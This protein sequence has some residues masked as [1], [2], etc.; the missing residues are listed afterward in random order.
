MES[1]MKIEDRRRSVSQALD[2]IPM[3][4]SDPKWWG[5]F[6]MQVAMEPYKELGTGK[7]CKVKGCA[8]PVYNTK[9]GRCSYH[10]MEE[11]EKSFEDRLR[12]RQKHAGG[13]SGTR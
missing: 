3:D 2:K 12:V 13:E 11:A 4:L 5:K 9:S 8:Q 10:R 1:V 7:R 6:S